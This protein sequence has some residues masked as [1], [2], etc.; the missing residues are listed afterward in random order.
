MKSKFLMTG[1]LSMALVFGM[2]VAG[3]SDDSGGG[4]GGSGDNGGG[5]NGGGIPA[6]LHGTWIKEDATAIIVFY[7]DKVNV[8]K[9]SQAAKDYSVSV[10]GKTIKYGNG[11]EVST[12]ATLC[13]DYRITGSALTLSGNE[14]WNGTHTLDGTYAKQ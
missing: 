2:M 6:E 14:E 10:S 9:S 8:T 12:W 5:G 1:I 7:A 4:D 3:C 13:T 11:G